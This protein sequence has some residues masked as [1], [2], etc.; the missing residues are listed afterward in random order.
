[1]PAPPAANIAPPAAVSATQSL[2][3]AKIRET[4]QEFES[5]FLNGMLEQMFEGVEEDGPFDSGEGGRIWR[6]LRTEEFARTI[7]RAGGIGLAEHVER[8]LIALQEKQP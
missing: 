6:S 8:Q 7:S 2:S 4:A 3:R 1:M 5:V